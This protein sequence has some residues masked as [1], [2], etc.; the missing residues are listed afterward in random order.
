MTAN[1]Q[2]HITNALDHVSEDSTALGHVHTALHELEHAFNAVEHLKVGHVELEEEIA[3]V[4]RMTDIV[5]ERIVVRIYSE[6]SRA[7]TL[8]ARDVVET[9]RSRSE[10]DGPI[11]WLTGNH[12]MPPLRSLPEA[13]RVWEEGTDDAWHAFS[14]RFF[15]A[16]EECQV[17]C[18]SPEDDN[19]LFCVDLRVWEYVDA[20][21]SGRAAEDT[22]GVIG[23]RTLDDDWRRRAPEGEESIGKLGEWDNNA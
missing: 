8:L 1:Q 5:R 14:E 23:E 17:L 19:S 16:L 3:A 6:A 9:V 22:P 10:Q 12:F 18:E 7:A 20:D 2:D 4:T 21:G 11:Q 15:E 13:E